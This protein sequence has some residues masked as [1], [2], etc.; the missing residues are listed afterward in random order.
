MGAVA[1]PELDI[2]GEGLGEADKPGDVLLLDEEPPEEDEDE[3]LEEEPDEEE[4][5]EEPVGA[6]E[7]MPPEEL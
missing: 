2:V 6:D 5:E 1:A 7:V 4:P 3:P